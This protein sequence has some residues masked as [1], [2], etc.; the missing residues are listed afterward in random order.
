MAGVGIADYEV[1]GGRSTPEAVVREADALREAAREWVADYLRQH[2]PPPKATPA[3]LLKARTAARDSPALFEAMRTAYPDML[4]THP[5]TFQFI[6]KSDRY[7][8]DVFRRYLHTLAGVNWDE[9]SDWL[10]S[11]ADYAAALY[12]HERPRADAREVRDYRA[13][14][15][16][17][18]TEDDKDFKEASDYAKEEVKR[19]EEAAAADRRRR[20]QQFMLK[21]KARVL[22]VSVDSVAAA[23]G[24]MRA[25]RQEGV[26]PLKLGSAMLAD[27][28]DAR[29]ALQSFAAHAAVKR[30]AVERAAV[31]RADDEETAAQ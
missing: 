18:L 2:P 28:P 11:Q 10:S 27:D 17:S 7:D 29:A 14:A 24:V 31:E 20:I 9:R 8:S 4:S 16:R 19:I 12:R 3:E 6:V 25:A 22:G 5:L 26:D 21:E 13:R 1:N 30:A 15:L 23:V